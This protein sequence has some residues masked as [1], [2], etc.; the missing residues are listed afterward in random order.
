MNL[1][2]DEVAHDGHPGEACQEEVDIAVTQED[3]EAKNFVNFVSMLLDNNKDKEGHQ[4]GEGEVQHNLVVVRPKEI[5]SR[6][7]NYFTIVDLKSADL[8]IM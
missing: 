6:C 7:C 8:K 1:I 4:H 3:T 5:H 2:K